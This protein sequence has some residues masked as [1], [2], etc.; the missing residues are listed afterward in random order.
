[1]RQSQLPFVRLGTS[2]PVKLADE[3]RLSADKRV[4]IVGSFPRQERVGT[5]RLESVL[6]SEL[7]K[8]TAYIHLV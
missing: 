1:M 5:E 6:R 8:A 7:W 2:F 4:E 3:G